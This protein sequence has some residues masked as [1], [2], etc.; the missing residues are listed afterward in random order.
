VSE[1]FLGLGSN[2]GDKDRNL[3]LAIKKL[4][5]HDIRLIKSSSFHDTDPVGGPPQDNFLN[6]VIQVETTHSPHHL[7][8]EIKAIERDM[9][10]RESVRNGPRI[11]DIDILLYDDVILT[12][13][14]LTIPHPRMFERDFVML[15]L[16]EIA[17]HI[18]KRSF[19]ADH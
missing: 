6:A 8:N 14:D 2:L 11:I 13:P 19:Y 1:I 16:R 18:N 10:R 5:E 3:K 17:P 15:P 4:N 7:L 12:T 9:G